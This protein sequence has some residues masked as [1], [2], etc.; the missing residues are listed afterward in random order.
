M[1]KQAENTFIGGL[2]TD[3]HPLTSQDNELTNARN[4][5][6]IAIGE[7]YQ[8]ILQKRE[9][10][11]ELFFL[12]SEW[13]TL[14]RYLTNEYVTELGITYKSLVDNNIHIDPATHPG[15]WQRQA[16]VLVPAGLRP[17]FI[18]LAVKEFNEVAYIISV[19]LNYSDIWNAV[20]SF[21]INTYVLYDG[22]VYKS[23]DIATNHIPAG[24]TDA[25]WE[26]QSFSQTTGEIG[27]FPSPDYT[28]F[29]YTTG[30]AI[31]GEA[32]IGT[33]IYDPRSNPPDYEFGIVGLL[34]SG[35]DEAVES[36]PDVFAK[37][38][39]TKG[40][41]RINNTGTLPDTYTLTKSITNANVVTKVGGAAYDY[42]LG[43]ISIF[44]GMHADVTFEIQH[45]F[46]AAY[47]AADTYNNLQYV[48]DSVNLYHSIQIVNVGHAL[49][50][51][52]WWASD[53]P[54]ADY[55]VNTLVDTTITITSAGLPLVPKTYNFKYHLAPNIAIR[56][57][58]DPTF[59]Y[60]FGN[61]GD[62]MH[63]VIQLGG[64]IVFCWI[65]N[66]SS[67][68]GSLIGFD[69]LPHQALNTA[70][71]LAHHVDI[72]F[73]ANPTPPGQLCKT[74]NGFDLVTTGI[75]IITTSLY[76]DQLH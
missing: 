69:T 12:P 51:P 3:R 60:V 1:D 59:T 5:D 6:L 32:A 68:V 19:K 25:F 15:S 58:T 45:P 70:T 43:T 39:L 47:N 10:N 30:T 24:V 38:T 16:T 61:I 41:F 64:E 14:S 23:L 44:P 49:S 40:G 26:L 54:I 36:L 21:P 34:H 22:L 62:T 76:A 28:Q 52:T 55:V 8:L 65:S 56:Y 50:D 72:H 57:E 46:I 29:L 63:S 9:G 27:T 18:P 20:S 2:N 53:G 75:T 42:V 74:V 13:N 35:D 66:D 73:T 17:G 67:M 31:P 48:T 7:G 71:A 4:I 37:F 11:Q 33:A